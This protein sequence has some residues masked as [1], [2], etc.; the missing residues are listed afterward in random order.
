MHLGATVLVMGWLLVSVLLAQVPSPAEIETA[1]TVGH[2]TKQAG[3]LVSSKLG[4]AYT[5]TIQ[6]PLGR[7]Q[8]LAADAARKLL[9]PPEIPE[10][11]LEPFLT[12][13]VTPQTPYGTLIPPA[14]AHVVLRYADGTV[15]QATALTP[16]PV[17]WSNLAGGQAQ[18]GGVFA[19][20]PLPDIAGEL[21]VV[22]VNVAGQQRVHTIKAKDRDKLR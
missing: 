21:A 15:I 4:S 22:V 2:R 8:A 19:R 5:V 11:L 18:S 10:G 12:V 9:P 3:G 16:F 17:S 14:V 1:R 7:V 13:H 6:G 20:F